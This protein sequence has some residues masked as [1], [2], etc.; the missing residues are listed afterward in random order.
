[1]EYKEYKINKD[2]YVKVYNL[3]KPISDYVDEKRSLNIYDDFNEYKSTLKR[4]EYINN[5]FNIEKD[6]TIYT[7]EDKN[8]VIAILMLI[9]N[10]KYILED[11]KLND[12]SDCVMLSSFYVNKKYRG[13]GS[14][15]LINYIFEKLKKSNIKYIY[16]KSSH[17]KAFKFYERLGYKIA[18]YKFLSDNKMYQRLGN[19]YKIE[20]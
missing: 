8:Q 5:N 20:L 12:I 2:N 13:I 19:I 6:L 4:I 17:Y 14:N 7:V 10:K 1:M 9:S 3:L 11:I 18:E 16:V 15:W